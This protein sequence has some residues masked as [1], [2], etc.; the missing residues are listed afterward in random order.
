M[1]FPFDNLRNINPNKNKKCFYLA[2]RLVLAVFLQT[3]WSCASHFNKQGGQ[4]V[5]LKMPKTSLSL[6]WLPSHSECQGLGNLMEHY[7]PQGNSVCYQSNTR[8]LNWGKS[9]TCFSSGNLCSSYG[10]KCQNFTKVKGFLKLARA[11]THKW[12]YPVRV[13]S[14]MQ[15]WLAFHHYVGTGTQSFII[16]AAHTWGVSKSSS[17]NN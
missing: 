9:E 6:L 16:S 8:L 7:N 3:S 14:S 11:Q 4:S 2:F 15:W 12:V 1:I 17:H 13:K 5:G 10:T